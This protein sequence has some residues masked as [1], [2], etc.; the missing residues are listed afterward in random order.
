MHYDKNDRLT[1]EYKEQVHILA[2]WLLNLIKT[3]YKDDVAIVVHETNLQPPGYENTPFPHWFIPATD[4]GRELE[5]SF[6]IAGKDH[7]FFSRSWDYMIRYENVEDYD[8]MMAAEACVLYAR[9]EL[10]RERFEEHKRKLFENLKN[11]GHMRRVALKDYHRAID[12]YKT[13]MLSSSLSTI[14]SMGGYVC[15]LLVHSIASINNR[16]I[17]KSFTNQFEF[18]KDCPKRPEGLVELYQKVNKSKN[19][20]EIRELC[21]CILGLMGNYLE[22]EERQEHKVNADG[23]AMWFEEM[24]EDWIRVRGFA[25]RNQPLNVRGWA[26]KLQYQINDASEQYGI[27]AYA[28]LEK[29]DENDMNQFIKYIDWVETDIRRIIHENNGR[30]N[31]FST[32]N[33]FLVSFERKEVRL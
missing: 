22:V 15:D 18:L 12:I 29:F 1:I 30:L 7:N 26:N 19:A 5:M 2:N 14:M 33:D 28:I 3:D 13:Y 6:I 17:L 10:D 4:R 21:V 24:I 8:T 31:D 16:Y 11:D 32:I 25:E 27:E 20:A 9:N 23:L